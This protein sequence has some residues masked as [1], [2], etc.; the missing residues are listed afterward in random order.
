MLTIQEFPRQPLH[1]PATGEAE[2]VARAAYSNRIEDP[3][4][5]AGFFG[6]EIDAFVVY[7]AHVSLLQ[8]GDEVNIA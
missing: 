7:R 1:L 2:V 8:S 6:H 4:V 5:P 3:S